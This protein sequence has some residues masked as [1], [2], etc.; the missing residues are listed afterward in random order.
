MLHRIPREPTDCHPPV[1]F[2][3]WFFF[4]ERVTTLGSIEYSGLHCFQLCQLDVRVDPL[5]GPPP[6]S[7]QCGGYC[8][9]IP[10]MS[11]H[12][13]RVVLAQSWVAVRTPH[14]MLLLYG[15]WDPTCSGRRRTRLE[16][17]VN[18]LFNAAASRIVGGRRCGDGGHLRASHPREA[19]QRA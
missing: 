17:R 11:K 16:L 2:F 15:E 1:D 3:F 5:S 12:V 8:G 10:P 19:C 14:R 7:F 6:H 18:G 9:M 13:Q 4:N